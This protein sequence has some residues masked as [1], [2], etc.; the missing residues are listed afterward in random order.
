[1]TP[2]AR[3]RWRV[4][5]PL[6]AASGAAWIALAAQWPVCS[7]HSLRAMTAHSALMFSA[8]M[9]PLVNAPLRHIRDRSFTQRRTRATAIF[10]VTYGAVWTA[11]GV[12][13]MMIAASIHAAIIVAAAM[14]WQFSPAKQRCLNRCHAH[15]ELAAF[16]FAADRDAL[17]F[18]SA[19]AVWCAASCSGLMLLPMLAGRGE[20]AAMAAVT[21]WIASEKLER[22]SPPQWAWRGPAKAVR[23]AHYWLMNA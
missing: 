4:G 19:H 22:A 11:A 8:M 14:L 5:L 17:R 23:I 6:F 1:M 9:L 7:A 12:V 13:L 15:P 18:G 10:I 3:E 2:A 20:I 21:L 16:G